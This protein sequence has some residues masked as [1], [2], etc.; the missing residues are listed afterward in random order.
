ML[1]SRFEEEEEGE[2]EEKTRRRKRKR[3]KERLFGTAGRV[4]VFNCV[5]K[6]CSSSS[7]YRVV[8]I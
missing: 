8:V 6:N 2:E 5:K 1:E 3:K 7:N 4:H